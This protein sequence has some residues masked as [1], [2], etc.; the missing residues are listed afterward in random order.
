MEE[1]VLKMIINYVLGVY[2]DDKKTIDSC[3]E[4]NTLF[5]NMMKNEETKLDRLLDVFPEIH[6][7]SIIYSEIK[8]RYD[9]LN[10]LEN[11]K[12]ILENA[13]IDSEC[14]KSFKDDQDIE[15]FCKKILK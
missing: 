3:I 8:N 12:E 1:K 2:E 13:D 5:T 9:L 4:V 11:S 6:P 10:L 14:L 7:V 15:E